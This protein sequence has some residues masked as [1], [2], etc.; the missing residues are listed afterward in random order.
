LLPY[1]LNTDGSVQGQKSKGVQRGKLVHVDENMVASPRNPAPSPS[2]KMKR[3]LQFHRR[4]VKM[5]N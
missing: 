2:F 5:N 4:L 1:T 3:T